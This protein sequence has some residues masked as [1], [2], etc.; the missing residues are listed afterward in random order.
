MLGHGLTF[1]TVSDSGVVSKNYMPP[2]ETGDATNVTL[3]PIERG[4]LVIMWNGVTMT[5]LIVDSDG[6][7]I[8]PPFSLGN[9]S[10]GALPSSTTAPFV[11]W[12]QLQDYA[13][14]FTRQ[15]EWLPAPPRIRVTRR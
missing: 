4:V 11:E 12:R 2:L 1:A 3:M 14:V 7:V 5:A 13:N 6:N 8:A 10:P 15:L 9:G